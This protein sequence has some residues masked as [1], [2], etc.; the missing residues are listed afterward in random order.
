MIYDR[1]RQ[2][3]EWLCALLFKYVKYDDSQWPVVV[4][5]K[6][7]LLDQIEDL[8]KGRVQERPARGSGGPKE[9]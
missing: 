2:Q 3:V 4:A 5:R 1:M 9:A 7:V 8:E 6:Q